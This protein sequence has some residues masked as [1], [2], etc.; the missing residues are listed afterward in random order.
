MSKRSNSVS[1][2]VSS[3]DALPENSPKQDNIPTRVFTMND[4][5][6]DTVSN[7][8]S[9]SKPTDASSELGNQT[10]YADELVPV[11]G[12]GSVSIC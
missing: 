2:S 4:S 9:A 3:T 11:P 8:A 5:E 6:P 10:Y 12:L 1:P 7:S